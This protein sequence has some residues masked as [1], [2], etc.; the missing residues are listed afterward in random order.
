[1][2]TTNNKYM[3]SETDRI[4]DPLID[5]LSILARIIARRYADKTNNSSEDKPDN[6]LIPT[7]KLITETTKG[8]HDA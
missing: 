1:M 2:S 6:T 4:S 7:I 5:G 3:D 8:N